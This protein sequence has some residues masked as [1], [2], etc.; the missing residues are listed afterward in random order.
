LNFLAIDRSETGL[1]DSL[2][3]FANI[4]SSRYLASFMLNFSISYQPPVEFL[5]KS[6]E[7][8]GE[9]RRPLISAGVS[10][11]CPHFDYKLFLTRSQGL[12]L[13]YCLFSEM[14][15]GSAG[16]LAGCR[17]SGELHRI[18]QL[19]YNLRNVF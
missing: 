5:T 2:L 16:R 3:I 13:K 1:L 12:F 19:E 18:G 7:K 8:M 6:A 9:A 14:S 10:T 17:F 4:S 11:T 15:S